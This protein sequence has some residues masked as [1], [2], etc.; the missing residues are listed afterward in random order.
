MIYIIIN[1]ILSISVKNVF[2]HINIHII[3]FSDL[4]ITRHCLLCVVYGTVHAAAILISQCR[5]TVSRGR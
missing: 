1:Y 5:L 4:C 3:F 2:L